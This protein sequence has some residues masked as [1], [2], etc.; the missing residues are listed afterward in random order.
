MNNT[1]DEFNYLFSDFLLGLNDK[2]KQLVKKLKRNIV[3]KNNYYP[4]KGAKVEEKDIEE[5]TTAAAA[6]TTTTATTTTTKTLIEQALMNNGSRD[7][8]NT[9]LQKLQQQLQDI[10][11]QV[12]TLLA[13]LYFD[14]PSFLF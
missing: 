1:N 12:S 3:N 6:A 11:E 5:E 10:K 13:F 9:D 4:F 8:S 2:I 7:I 14:C